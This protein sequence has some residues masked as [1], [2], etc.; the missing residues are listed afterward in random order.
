MGRRSSRGLLCVLFFIW[1][2]GQDQGS[3]SRAD[4]WPQWL[5][6]GREPVWNESGVVTSFSKAG[7]PL[8]WKM[9]IGG[10]YSGP[11]V[12]H[13][14]VFLMDR[15]H[16]GRD[17]Q[18]G[19][20]LHKDDPPNNQNFVRRE[21]RGRERVVCLNEADGKIL[22][23]HEYDCPYTTVA[24]YAIGPRCTPTVDGEFV[25][26]LG[27]EGDLRCL[28]VSDGAL[29]WSRSFKRDYGAAIPDWG[30]AAH[31]LIDGDRLICA[32]GGDGTTCVAFD[33]RDG[34]EIWRSLSAKET[35][36]CPPVIVEVGAERHVVIWDS[37]GVVG[38]DPESGR[39]FW[40][41]PFVAAFAMSVG[42]P[43][44]EGRSLFVMCFSRKSGTIRIGEDNRSAEL[45]WRGNPRH[46]IGGVFNTPVLHEGHVYGCG[47]DGRY[48]CAK[49][50]SGD[51]IWSTFEPSTGRRPA[52][53]ANVFTI[54][55][56]DHYFLANDL[57]DLIIARMS[58]AG[59][60]EVSRAHLIDPTHKVAGRTLVWSHP[61][62]ANRSI[63]LRNDKE[64]RC[65]S[66][67][68]P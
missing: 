30:V 26:T 44:M 40:S 38:M 64:I 68:K 57:G 16:E 3:I 14:R 23:T 21:L 6:P 60:E 52:S 34:K 1:G 24:I 65:Y 12:A 31:P 29:V 11:A 4:D 48:I 62:F 8:R 45:I 66:L 25:Y 50:D 56:G 42:T 15:V 9:A 47:Q 58:P 36:Y 2:P 35:G 53:W 22:W 43:Q 37:E 55:N 54:R 20:L 5:G 28:N 19:P 33:K 59:Y 51:R 49:L 46:G 10:G 61:A 63:Y 13:G 39:Q 18:D 17:L 32:V 67:K 7:P 41:V 27:A